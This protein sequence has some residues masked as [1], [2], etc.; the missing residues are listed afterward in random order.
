MVLVAQHCAAYLPYVNAAAD[1]LVVAMVHSITRR[2]TGSN[3]IL[4]ASFIAF[5]PVFVLGSTSGSA[6]TLYRALIIA[7]L[8][9]AFVAGKT[10]YSG[11]ILAAAVYCNPSYTLLLL[12]LCCVVG[13]SRHTGHSRKL[14]MSFSLPRAVCALVG[15]ALALYGMLAY[16][17]SISGSWDF[18][19]HVYAWRFRFDDLTPNV[20]MSWY[21][22][23]EV[24]RFQ[25]Y[26]LLLFLLFPVTFVV[27]LAIWFHRKPL[28]L[29]T[30]TYSL[31]EYSL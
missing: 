26:Y 14:P 1:C 10:F 23:A 24:L 17:K 20:G 2:F 7:A 13:Y 16:S 30:A 9:V 18:V 12:P 5:N 27:P 28:L 3:S 8:W 31:R 21:F 11:M 22:F 15:F 25:Q 19:Y 29:F 4:L 6:T